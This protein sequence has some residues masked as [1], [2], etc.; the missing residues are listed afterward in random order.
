[1]PYSEE[2]ETECL[3]WE[4]WRENGKIRISKA[5]DIKKL[6]GWSPDRF[7]SCA[8]T[9][10]DSEALFLP[11]LRIKSHLYNGAF[12]IHMK[13]EIK[14]AATFYYSPTKPSCLLVSALHSSGRFLIL[15]EFYGHWIGVKPF[16]DRVRAIEK[17]YGIKITECY[18]GSEL[19]EV[20]YS[21]NA[22]EVQSDDLLLFEFSKHGLSFVR[23]SKDRLTG[24]RVLREYLDSSKDATRIKFLTKSCYNTIRTLPLLTR[25]N[26]TS[27]SEKEIDAPDVNCEASAA[28]C[29]RMLVM[30]INPPEKIKNRPKD[31]VFNEVRP[32][33]SIRF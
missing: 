5:D 31:R 1:L 2:L 30:Q 32:R 14:F 20:N 17:Q 8:L 25:R 3:A 29:L 22:K 10:A 24:W 26:V 33:R 27:H 18:T 11:K 4:Y 13:A 9:F 12:S 19:G 15:G 28:H 6:I 21:E 23:A 7:W 16:V